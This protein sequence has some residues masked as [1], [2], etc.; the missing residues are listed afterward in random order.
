MITD[1]MKE[2]RIELAYLIQ[3]KEVAIVSMFSDNIRIR[4]PVKVLLITNEKKQLPEGVFM[5]R[6]LN[7]F[8]EGS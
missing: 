3:S 8:K 4:Q 1:I 2:K 6:E 5:G 7:A